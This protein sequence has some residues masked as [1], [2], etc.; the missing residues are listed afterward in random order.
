VDRDQGR[1]LSLRLITGLPTEVQALQG[2]LEAA[3]S[4]YLAVTGRPAGNA[5]AHST[6][7]ALPLDK[8]GADQVVR[9]LYAGEAMIGCADVIRGY[10]AREKAVIGLLL[11]AQPWQRRG[12]GRAFALRIEQAIG[13]WPEIARQRL[14]V[15]VS[16]PG[17]Q[18]FWRK[19]GYRETGEVRPAP[20][21]MA[22]AFRVMEKPLHKD[23]VA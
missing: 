18:A 1:P 2:V 20:P 13:G 21:S 3:P 8:T 7:T 19:L 6:L 15:A 5:E 9:G 14:G 10:P 4:Y 17:A 12:H 16:N 23:V 22:A 11:L